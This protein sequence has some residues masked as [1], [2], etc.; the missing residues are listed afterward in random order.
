M[1]NRFKMVIADDGIGFDL[2]QVIRQ[3]QHSGLNNM[4]TR[5]G[6][7]AAQLSIETAPGKGTKLFI[8]KEY[9]HV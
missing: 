6:Q 5:A 2:D 3:N 7:I 4:F 1:P 8:S 9:Q